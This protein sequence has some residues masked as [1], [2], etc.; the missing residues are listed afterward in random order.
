MCSCAR[1]QHLPAGLV[2]PNY[3]T[4]ASCRL[5][6]P[7]TSIPARTPAF[8]ALLV[9]V[10]K[11]T[12]VF[13]TCPEDSDNLPTALSDLSSLRAFSMTAYPSSTILTL[14]ARPQYLFLTSNLQQLDIGVQNDEHVY[15]HAIL[16]AAA[17]P[18]ERIQF[19]CQ[20]RMVQVHVHILL[21]HL[22][23][24]RCYHTSNS[25]ASATA[26]ASKGRIH[27]QDSN[28]ALTEAAL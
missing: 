4:G 21:M 1:S 27:N 25:F 15:P 18:L 16:C 19:F 8:L 10:P 12:L 6:L 28:P 3:G 7:S 9:A 24:T 20:S 13:V 23:S 17:D 2:A 11:I 26:W 22:C 5:R 14:L